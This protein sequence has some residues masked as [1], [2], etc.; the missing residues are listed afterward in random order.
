M[1]LLLAATAL[2]IALAA[3]GCS[4]GAGERGWLAG[5]VVDEV[6]EV[7][8]PALASPSGSATSPAG[9]LGLGTRT[10]VSSVEVRQGDVVE[11]GQVLVRFDDRLLRENVRIA[12]A[13]EDVAKARTRLLRSRRSDVG[14]RQAQIADARGEL[15]STVAELTSTRARLVGQLVQ[16]RAALARLEAMLGSLPPS[17]P[18]TAPAPPP[19]PPPGTPN[20]AALRAGISRLERPIAQIDQGLAKARAARSTLSDARSQTLTAKEA[21]DDAIELSV[22]GEEASAAAVDVA[23]AQVDLFVVVAPVDGVVISATRPGEVWAPGATVVSLRPRAASTVRTWVS[24]AQA[25]TIRIEAPARVTAD[26]A[27]GRVFS[28]KVVR[29][30]EEAE[31]PPTSFATSVIHLTRAVRVEVALEESRSIPAGTP[32]D[33]WIEER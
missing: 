13:V 28:A 23:K 9:S 17:P 3:A 32:V 1:R 12:E 4:G 7:S 22:L 6:V 26:W 21:L 24:L 14:D 33:V 19:S 20:P 11:A 2:M 16:A 5:N 10:R 27:R 31:M 8:A 25:R 18:T 29:V 30:G 15:D